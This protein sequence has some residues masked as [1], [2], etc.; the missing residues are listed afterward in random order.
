[1]SQRGKGGFSHQPTTVCV[2]LMWGI[3][4][5]CICGVITIFSGVSCELPNTLETCLVVAL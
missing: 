5:C 2:S 4:T 1:M 3:V